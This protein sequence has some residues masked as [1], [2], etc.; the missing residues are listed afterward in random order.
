MYMKLCYFLKVFLYYNLVIEHDLKPS[1][2][3]ERYTSDG[4]KPC[5]TCKFCILAC[6]VAISSTTKVWPSK[7]NMIIQR[8]KEGFDV[9]HVVIW[10]TT[11]FSDQFTDEYLPHLMRIITEMVR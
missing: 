5:I 2:K 7:R 3:I 8:A 10:T 11:D 9:N 4:V 1:L 6:A